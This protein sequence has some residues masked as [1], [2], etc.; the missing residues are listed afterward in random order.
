MYSL[1]FYSTL[2]REYILAVEGKLPAQKA[3]NHEEVEASINN[4]KD[5]NDVDDLMEGGEKEGEQYGPW[6]EKRDTTF[7]IDQRAHN[8][9][10][11]AM[12][13]VFQ[14]IFIY[15]LYFYLTPKF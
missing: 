2:K 14:I 5:E 8:L 1:L 9:K 4:A 6:Q 13:Q 15:F 11:V 12:A 3:V 7:Q 10:M